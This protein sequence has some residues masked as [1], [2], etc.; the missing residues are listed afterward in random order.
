M[1]TQVTEKDTCQLDSESIVLTS[2]VSCRLISVKFSHQE[3]GIYW[4]Q[5][6][7]FVLIATKYATKI[8]NPKKKKKKQENTNLRGKS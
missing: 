6:S 2:L 8:G 7:L 1:K 5:P 4:Y 3:F